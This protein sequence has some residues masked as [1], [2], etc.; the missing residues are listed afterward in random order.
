MDYYAISMVII[1]YDMR[2]MSFR[3]ATDKLEKTK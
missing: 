2:T 3:D 1:Q